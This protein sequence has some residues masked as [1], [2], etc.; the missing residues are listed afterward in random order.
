MFDNEA[1]RGMKMKPKNTSASTP[2]PL[3]QQKPDTSSVSEMLTPPEIEQLRQKKKE[4]TAFGQKA[5][6]HLKP[7]LTPSEIEQLRQSKKDDI[8]YGLKAFA[9][10]R[11]TKK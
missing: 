5:F 4:L 1:T 7:E 2:K 8:A 3:P 10:L 9:H 6:A 11:P